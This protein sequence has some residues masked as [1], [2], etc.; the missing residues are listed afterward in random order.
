MIFQHTWEKVLNGSKTKTTRRLYFSANEP[1]PCRYK[2]GSTYAVQKKRMG[3]GIARIKIL[4]VEVLPNLRN[5]TEEYARE[6]GF[7]SLAEFDAAFLRLNK[8]GL[9][10]PVYSIAFEL[11]K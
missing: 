4:S 2:V 11:E 1:V 5:I 8:S 6:E 7:S 9:D 3:A 10:E